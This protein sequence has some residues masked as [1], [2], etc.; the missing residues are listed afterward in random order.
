SVQH[1]FIALQA[2]QDD[3]LCLASMPTAGSLGATPTTGAMGEKSRLKRHRPVESLL[4]RV[5]IEVGSLN[6]GLKSVGEQEAILAG[7]AAFLNS[8]GYPVQLLTRVLPLDVRPY[9][10]SYQA[11]FDM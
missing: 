11:R 9:L 7:Y 4:Y 3:L 1:G 2:A 5:V 6:F 8:L 10:T